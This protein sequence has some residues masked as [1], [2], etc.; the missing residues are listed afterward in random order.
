MYKGFYTKE[1]IQERFWKFWKQAIHFNIDHYNAIQ[2]L[3]HYSFSPYIDEEIKK[4]ANHVIC[5]PLAKL[6][7]EAI[8]QKVF[9]EL[10]PTIMVLMHYGSTVHLAKAHH[11]N[12][13]NL[14]DEII[15]MII[16]SCWNSVSA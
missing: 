7:S 13:T 15:Q 6:Y 2:F 12:S 3:E 10:E 11:A 5:E 4:D 8:E 9:I 16:Q 1:S 14:T